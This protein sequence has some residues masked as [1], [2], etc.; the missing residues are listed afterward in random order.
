MK[1]NFEKSAGPQLVDIQ[2][3]SEDK[4]IK[5]DKCDS[6]FK[7]NNS[8]ENHMKENHSQEL[9]YDECDFTVNTANNM[10]EHMI[11]YHRNEQIDGNSESFKTP[12][13]IEH[14][15]RYGNID[16]TV[17]CYECDE[18]YC[19]RLG[20]KRH[21]HNEHNKNVFEDININMHGWHP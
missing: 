13:E 17:W 5:C 4:I 14:L 6:K 1:K 20:L 9:S 18:E 19:S 10:E 21:M 15:R 3:Q 2:I 16:Y 8:L 12:G 11:G 7:C